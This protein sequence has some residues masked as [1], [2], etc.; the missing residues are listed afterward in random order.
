MAFE[1]RRPQGG[2]LAQRIKRPGAL[3]A[4]GSGILDSPAVFRTVP[5]RG[6]FRKGNAHLLFIA[7]SDPDHLGPG[8]LWL[9]LQTV[10]KK[11]RDLTKR[12]SSKARPARK[13]K[14]LQKKNPEIKDP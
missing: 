8:P 13:Y 9:F 7:L 10:R 14:F 2:G 5:L 12:G 4:G 1:A 6:T 11:T 3:A